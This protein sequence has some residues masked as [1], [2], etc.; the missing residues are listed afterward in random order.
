MCTEG[1]L[2][3]VSPL[4]EARA[5]EC[6]TQVRAGAALQRFTLPPLK[7]RSALSYMVDYH[8]ERVWV[9]ERQCYATHQGWREY[10]V[11]NHSGVGGKRSLF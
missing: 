3:G 9:P 8:A 7:H 6:P 2:A 1:A 5:Y 4:E 10:V 11:P